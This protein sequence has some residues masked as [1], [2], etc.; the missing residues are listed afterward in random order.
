M[1]ERLAVERY[2]DP[3]LLPFVTEQRAANDVIRAQAPSQP[4]IGSVEPAIIR[5]R[6]IYNRDGSFRPALAKLACDGVV[7]TPLGD[8]LVRSVPSSED[9]SLVVHFHGGGWIFGSVYEQ[10]W[11][12]EQIAAQ[13]AAAVLSVDYPLA[14]ESQLPR[15]VAVAA[16]TLAAII[17]ANPDRPIAVVGES[18]GAHIA[19][20]GV[21]ALPRDQRRQICGMSLA[22]GIYDLSMT[23]SQRTWGS[24]FLGL[25]TAWLEYFYSQTL[26]GL[27]R[28]ERGDARYSPLR[29]DLAGLPPTLFSVGQ[30][31]PLLD[32]SLLMFDCWL[33]A[34][35][36]GWLRIYPEAVH[37]FN[38]LKTRMA[39][40]CNDA[41]FTFLVE[42]FARW[43]MLTQVI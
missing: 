31:D 7:S 23:P 11:L 20:S 32:D 33:A 26:P 40:A 18:A 16:A 19:L 8:V 6:R 25:S 24:E 21:L 12:L 35:N 30:L 4:P 13:T 34:G 41:I 14:P 15:A 5:Q 9:G 28:S 38:H 22:Y 2:I 1:S 43:R 42:R 29:A 27:A 17:S 10:D 3:A 37:G 39:H 36:T